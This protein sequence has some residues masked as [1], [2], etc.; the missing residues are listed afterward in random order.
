MFLVN[1][2]LTLSTLSSLILGL[3]ILVSNPSKMVNRALAF[4]QLSISL[5]LIAN[6]LTNLSV[7]PTQAL[8]FARTTLIGAAL[9]PLAFVLFCKA[10]THQ[11][12][13]GHRRFFLILIAPLILIATTPTE[14]NIVSIH[15]Y[16]RDT[17]TGSIYAFLVPMVVAY[18]AWGLAL[19][20]GYYRH[21]KKVIEKVQTKYIF[22]GVIL[23]LIPIVIANG[24]LPIF[25]N[26]TGIL[27]GPDFV[28]LLAA[29]VSVAIIRHRLLDIRLI[30]AR[31]LA[32]LLSLS[33]AI[34]LY[35]TLTFGIALSI[36]GENK[37][38]QRIV[39]IVM[40]IFLAFT[41]QPLRR[42]FARNTNKLFYRD[43][44]DTQEFLN[45]FNNTLVSTYDLELLLER[46][47]EVIQEN[48]KPLHC[49]FIINSTDNTAKRVLG[50]PEHPAFSEKDAMLIAKLTPFMK[51]EPIVTDLLE[52]KQE[53]LQKVLQYNDVAILARLF[54]DTSGEETNLGYLLL[55][56]KKSG[57]L[58]NS[59]DTKVIEIIISELVIAIQNAL[60]L[61]EIENFNATLQEKI[62]DA[63][64]KLRRVNDKLRRLN[65]TKD[66]FISMASHQLRTPL[67]S[68]KGYVS[69]VLDGDAGK[70][71][72]LQRRLLN[73]SF[74]S[75]QRMVYLIS[76]LLNVSR[77]K[78]GK[79][80][81]E[82]IQCNLAKV[83]QEEVE[84]LVE[85]AKSR[86]LTLEYHKPEH[87]PVFLLDETKLRQ[88][89][90]NFLDNAVY[91]TPAEGHIEVHLVDKP[92][93]IEFTVTDDGIGVPRYE[94][95]HLFTKFFRA[96][97]AK[98]ARPDGTG[99]G[100]FMAKKVII[101]Q[102]GAVIFRSHEGKGSTFGFTFAKSRIMVGLL[103]TTK[104]GSVN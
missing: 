82:P 22:A 4:F 78:T 77:L 31:S 30:V 17:V 26:N 65:E 70:I 10:F 42:F 73:Q 3:S 7:N 19:L 38:S 36:F 34:I 64:H 59:Q 94:Q 58:Y 75:S 12:K 104:Q 46:S 45:K 5:W 81:I 48:L 97:N 27:Y 61:E 43:A 18:F 95:H 84:Q 67:T 32:Y 9:V 25:G 16:G 56:R 21:T 13:M 53:R 99:L 60:R 87:F 41:I 88:V 100:L 49:M 89:I 37:F 93:T 39:P 14:L 24:I 8:W 52:E 1:L 50:T 47:A 92:Q 74:V 66:D 71:T 2:L 51:R 90:M 40:A 54:V 44:Y 85:T 86:H 101:A 62:D 76:D 102:G 35:A 79:F 80:I 11:A 33:T 15:A 83:V 23:A 96:P 69:M 20:I 103:G 55:G 72:R 29:F 68:V 28:T 91:Y 98:R 6:L 57:N 63:T